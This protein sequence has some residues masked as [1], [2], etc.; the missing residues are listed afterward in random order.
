M[1]TERVGDAMR[2]TLEMVVDGDWKFSGGELR[3]RLSETELSKV[4]LTGFLRNEKT[5]GIDSFVLA[6]EAEF[7]SSGYDSLT[8]ELF[9]MGVAKGKKMKIS[10]ILA[11]GRRDVEHGVQVSSMEYDLGSRFEVH[12][13]SRLESPFG[14]PL[15]TPMELAKWVNFMVDNFKGF[16]GDDGDDGDD[17]NEPEWTPSTGP[18]QLVGV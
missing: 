18:A 1:P 2:K 7:D 3:P 11:Y 4:R 6:A 10:C 12:G 5:P 13:E 16:K 15:G 9:S 14:R 17:D 8:G